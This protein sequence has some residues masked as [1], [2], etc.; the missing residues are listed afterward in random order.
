MTADRDKAPA[1]SQS[2]H[3]RRKHQRANIHLQAVLQ[4]ERP[5]DDVRLTILNFSVGGFFC[6]VSR[7]LELMTKLGIQFRFP[8]FA[9]QDGKEIEATA[10]VVR[11]QE[12][13]VSDGPF[14]L[15]ACFIDL[16]QDA[17]E[18]IQSY[19]DWY[20]MVHGDAEVER[21]TV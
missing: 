13:D 11:C 14:K 15:A 20:R 21:E 10:L 16:S 17:R 5:E 7:P 4:G 12:P 3:D 2:G 6:E 18:H 8:P 9:D 19:V 1:D